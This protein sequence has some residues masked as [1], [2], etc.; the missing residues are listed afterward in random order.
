MASRTVKDI[1]GKQDL[2]SIGPGASVSE[3]VARM[4]A[5]NVAA[6]LVIEHGVVAG[7]FTE[8]DL[9]KR[10]VAKG[11]D[12]TKTPIAAVMTREPVAVPVDANALSAMRTMCRHNIRH[13]PVTD[14]LRAVGIVSIRDFVGGEID[15]F[16]RERDFQEHLWE[17]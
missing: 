17:G 5:R 4:D 8:R 6:I 3:A 10:V 12:P 15:E 13:L 2:L 9:L 7:I 14:G 11:C 1:V 16:E